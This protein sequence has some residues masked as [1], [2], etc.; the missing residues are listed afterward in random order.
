MYKVS[1][2]LLTISDSEDSTAKIS[3]WK[4]PICASSLELRSPVKLYN[5]S[6]PCARPGLNQ[7]SKRNLIEVKFPSFYMHCCVFAC[8]KAKKVLSKL[9]AGCQFYP[10]VNFIKLQQTCQF[11]RIEVSQLKSGSFQVVICRLV[12]TCWRNFKNAIRSKTVDKSFINH[13]ATGLYTRWQFP[14]DLANAP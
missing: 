11:H 12:T 4:W 3:A 6:E 10:L 9:V 8:S 7:S 14:T 13:L 2:F 1:Y 5:G